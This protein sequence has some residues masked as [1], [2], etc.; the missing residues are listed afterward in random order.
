MHGGDG[1]DRYIVTDFED[2]IFENADEGRDRVHSA[3]SF[4]LPDNVEIL[5][6]SGEGE[7]NATGNDLDNRLIGNRQANEVLGLG[8]VDKINGRGGRD[9]LSGGDGS[10]KLNGGIGHDELYGGDGDDKLRGAGGQD[11]LDGGRGDDKIFGGGAGDTLVFRTGDG[12]DTVKG[13]SRS[14]DEVLLFGITQDE[15]SSI[16]RNG[17]VEMSFG[18]DSVFF[19][20]VGDGEID[21]LLS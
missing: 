8:G 20:G 1:D 2:L 3:V 10:D 21:Y 12:H 4:A 16:A 7:M 15:I 5:R 14:A 13:F 6:L 11:I 9:T 17:G 18:A 19:A